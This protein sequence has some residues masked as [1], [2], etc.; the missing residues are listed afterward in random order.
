MKSTS[1][2]KGFTLIEVIIAMILLSVGLLT[3]LSVTLSGMLQR[4]VT[5]EYDIAREAANAR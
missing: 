3:L 2:Q 1:A 4:E 5:R